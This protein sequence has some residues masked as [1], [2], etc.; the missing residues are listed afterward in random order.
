MGVF[1]II[2]FMTAEKVNFL[3]LILKSPYLGY[4]DLYSHKPNIK[5][6]NK[7]TDYSKCFSRNMLYCNMYE[8]ETKLTVNQV[9][10]HKFHSFNFSPS[11]YQA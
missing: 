10:I 1:L 3:V 5:F 9:S 2:T 7:T 8:G 11:D 6:Q 4:I